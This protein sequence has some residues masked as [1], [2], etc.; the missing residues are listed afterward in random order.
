MLEKKYKYRYFV[1]DVEEDVVSSAYSFDSDW[2]DEESLHKYIAEDAAM[3]YHSNHDGWECSWP[4][5]IYLYR[6]DGTFIGKFEVERH[7]VPEFSAIKC[8]EEK[9][10]CAENA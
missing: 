10:E 6:D 5:D 3:D 9:K 8:K 1:N 4:E 7:S 2:S